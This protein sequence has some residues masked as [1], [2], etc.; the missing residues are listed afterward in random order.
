MAKRQ[1]SVRLRILL[2]PGTGIGPGKA[3]LMEGID[4]TGSIAAAGRRIGMSYKRAWLLMN[5]LNCDFPQPLIEAS[6]GGKSGGGA[7]LTPLG[8]EVLATFRNMEA[9]TET[10][11]AP[12][13][14][15][16][17]NLQKLH[18]K[19]TP[20][21]PKDQGVNDDHLNKAPKPK[22]EAKPKRKPK[23]KNKAASKTFT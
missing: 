7:C 17:E 18:A 9:L 21:K 12:E 2:N 20:C 3:D 8:K 15:R 19:R 5:A 6:K 10:A 14:A 11:I 1:R 16:L 13:L 22:A 23:P 4:E